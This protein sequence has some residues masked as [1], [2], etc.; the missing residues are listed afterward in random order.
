MTNRCL[1]LRILP[2]AIVVLSATAGCGGEDIAQVSLPNS[3]FGKRANLICTNAANEQ[4]KNAGLYLKTHPKADEAD[5][6]EPVGIPP[7]EKELE[8][9]EELGL[10]RG[11][12]VQAE[13]FIEEFEMALETLKKDPAA[14]LSTKENPFKKANSLARRFQ[15]GDCSQSP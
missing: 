13:A 5:M 11:H 1:T 7:L 10:P 3:Q 12:E 9:L 14:A 15:Y 8:E 6:I 2:I 4:F